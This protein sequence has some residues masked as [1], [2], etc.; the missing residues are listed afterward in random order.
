[1]NP[2]MSEMHFVAALDSVPQMRGVLTLFEGVPTAAADGHARMAGRPAIREISPDFA[3][4]RGNA[5]TFLTLRSG[6]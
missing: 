5:N 3:G 2:G 6:R 4:G 1:M